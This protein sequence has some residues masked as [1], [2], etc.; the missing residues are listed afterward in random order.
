MFP[1]PFWLHKSFRFR[2]LNLMGTKESKP[3]EIQNSEGNTRSTIS[4][5]STLSFRK[6]TS[7]RLKKFEATKYLILGPGEA[8]KSTFFRQLQLLQENFTKEELQNYKRVIQ[9]NILATFLNIFQNSPRF[10]IWIEPR[11]L[12]DEYLA[13]LIKNNLTEITVKV[14]TD[15]KILYSSE[16]F[17]NIWKLRA[18]LTPPVLENLSYFMSSQ[19][20]SRI[21]DPSYVPTISD[22]QQE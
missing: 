22:V 17:Q 2:L 19:N 8:G 18:T 14:A 21:A 6:T 10:A 13:K 20:L 4:V 16:G 5:R 15:L 7:R 1:R 3:E 9:D 11:D 12:F